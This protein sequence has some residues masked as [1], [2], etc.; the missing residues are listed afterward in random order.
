MAD[1]G[2]GDTE[3]LGGFAGAYVS[4]K[5]LDLAV[6]VAVRISDHVVSM[7]LTLELRQRL[8]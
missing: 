1:H 3:P 6:E 7:H 8:I 5:R 4:D 2:G